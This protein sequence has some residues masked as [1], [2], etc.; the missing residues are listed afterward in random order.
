[1]VNMKIIIVNKKLLNSCSRIMGRNMIEQ[2]II[3]AQEL[4]LLNF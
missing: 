1:M 4:L 2:E 3:K